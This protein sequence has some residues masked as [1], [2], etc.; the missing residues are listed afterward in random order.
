LHWGQSSKAHTITVSLNGAQIINQQ[1]NQGRFSINLPAQ[2]ATK[3]ADITFQTDDIQT[4]ELTDVDFGKVWIAGGQSNME[5]PMEF[6]GEEEEG[7]K[8]TSSFERWM[9]FDAEDS[10]YFSAVGAYFALQLRKTLDVPVGIISCN[11][12]GT[13]AVTWL[14]EKKIAANPSISHYWKDYCNNLNKIS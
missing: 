6:D 11:W 1:I 10:K 9:Y 5:F 8:D 2:P 13:S 3:N 12:G 7:L 4:V 14:D